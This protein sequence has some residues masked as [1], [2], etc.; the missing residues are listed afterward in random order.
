MSNDRASR[1]AKR[2]PF[3][4][5]RRAPDTERSLAKKRPGGTYDECRGSFQERDGARKSVAAM[6]VPAK[7]PLF[8]DDGGL[9]LTWR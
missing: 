6:K 2:Q 7:D 4:L 9:R 5:A 1:N 8:G 3:A